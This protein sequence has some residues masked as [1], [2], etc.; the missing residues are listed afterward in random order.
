MMALAVG[1]HL[2]IIHHSYPLHTQRCNCRSAHCL[3]VAAE[4]LF[5]E[6][7]CEAQ[8]AD[9]AVPRVT[10]EELQ[11][12]CRSESSLCV[13][14]V[15][16]MCFVGMP[17]AAASSYF[18]SGDIVINIQQQPPGC[19]RHQSARQAG[20]ALLSKLMCNSSVHLRQG[21]ELILQLHLSDRQPIMM[22]NRLPDVSVRQVLGHQSWAGC[23]LLIPDALLHHVGFEAGC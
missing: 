2:L 8:H 20:L 21:L 5:P 11:P 23:T 15:G 19:C 10:Q 3:I 18:A 14:A 7:W 6:A 22:F 12:R 13:Q 17:V 9:R 4:Y 16:S 1:H